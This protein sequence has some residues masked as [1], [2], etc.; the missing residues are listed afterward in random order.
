MIAKVEKI[1]M[2]ISKKT[3]SMFQISSKKTVSMFQIRVRR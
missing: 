1:N 2:Y 3:V